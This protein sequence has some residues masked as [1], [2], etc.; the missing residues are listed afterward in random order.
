MK[1]REIKGT[2]YRSLNRC[3]FFH[4]AGFQIL[5]KLTIHHCTVVYTNN[6]MHKSDHGTE[7]NICNEPQQ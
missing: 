4:A 2:S 3:K 5:S 1:F 7:R 6:G